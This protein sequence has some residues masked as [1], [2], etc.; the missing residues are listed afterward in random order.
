MYQGLPT[1]R[2]GGVTSRTDFLRVEEG[3]GHKSAL[4]PTYFSHNHFSSSL[5][6]AK[7]GRFEYLPTLCVLAELSAGCLY[8]LDS[9]SASFSWTD[10]FVYNVSSYRDY[11]L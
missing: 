9:Y 1:F 8:L 2:A 6:A 3:S 5:A 7:G 4:T 11:R 10:G